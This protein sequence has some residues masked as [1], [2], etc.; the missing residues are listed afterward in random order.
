MPGVDV[1]RDSSSTLSTYIQY[2]NGG[3][4]KGDLGDF[5]MLHFGR[6]S[7]DY[8]MGLGIDGELGRLLMLWC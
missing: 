7:E 1:P 5:D 6:W 3:K 8:S 4:G 2:R